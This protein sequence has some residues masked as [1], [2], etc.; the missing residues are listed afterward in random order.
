MVWTV[1]FKLCFIKPQ[2][3]SVV[4]LYMG[5][6]N[7]LFWHKLNI[8]FS[9]VP[10][11]ESDVSSFFKLR[12]E[13][14]ELMSGQL[15]LDWHRWSYKES[16]VRISAGQVTKWGTE[17]SSRFEGLRKSQTLLEITKPHQVP[18]TR[19]WTSIESC[20]C[21]LGNLSSKGGSGSVLLSLL[22]KPKLKELGDTI[23][24]CFLSCWGMFT[25]VWCFSKSLIKSTPCSP[26]LYF[27]NYVWRTL[28]C[29]PL[30]AFQN[31]PVAGNSVQSGQNDQS[32]VL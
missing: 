12:R 3:N 11:T 6:V 13:E 29:A 27:S 8:G 5:S 15:D 24:Q 25:E 30:P 18:E 17:E 22:L 16:P 4:C 2:I 26:N 1:F 32:L 28:F 19:G 10:V 14:I 23:D 21:V 9:L 7:A 31:I 20:L